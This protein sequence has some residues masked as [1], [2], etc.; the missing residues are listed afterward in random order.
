MRQPK[1]IAIAGASGLVGSNI[2]RAALERGYGVNGTL[3]S[4]VCRFAHTLN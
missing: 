3:R 4:K 1:T 2:I